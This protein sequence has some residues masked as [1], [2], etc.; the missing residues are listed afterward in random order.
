MPAV[1]RLDCLERHSLLLT[2]RLYHGLVR[3]GRQPGRGNHVRRQAAGAGL[4]AHARGRHHFHSQDAAEN[5]HLQRPICRVKHGQRREAVGR[6][7]IQAD[8]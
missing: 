5:R 4:R 7:R 2:G 8:Q 1:L 3:L 6:A